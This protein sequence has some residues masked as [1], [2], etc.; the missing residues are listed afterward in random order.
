MFI[1][2]K[3]YKNN[4]CKEL[5]SWKPYDGKLSRAVWERILNISRRIVYLVHIIIESL[6]GSYEISGFIVYWLA[7]LSATLTSLYS[8]RILYLTFFNVPNSSKYTYLNLHEMDNIMVIPMIILAIGSIFVGYITRDIYLGMGSPFNAI[9]IHPNN[10]NLI[11]TEFGLNSIFKVLPL[12]TG[13]GGSLILLY[14]YEFNY[15]LINVYNNSI[16][17]KIYFFLNQKVFSDQLINNIIIRGGLTVGGLLNHHVDKGLLK[18]FG[19][20]GLWKL[21]NIISSI[22]S[23]LSVA[24]I[25]TYALYLVIGVIVALIFILN[26][27]NF[28]IIIL[29]L[30]TLS[31]FT[32]KEDI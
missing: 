6:L 25:F 30:W 29:L 10:L 8:M 28:S 32:Q 11:E 7:L 20:N 26:K 27:L 1:F 13:L 15:H 4:L 5:T 17:N 18:L 12:I 19:P 14:I 16:F 23:K 22:L 2:L 31:L 3:D 24:S 9:F 21:S